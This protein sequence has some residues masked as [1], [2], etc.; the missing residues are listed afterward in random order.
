MW[1]CCL[2]LSLRWLCFRLW[3]GIYAG[4][5]GFRLLFRVWCF[6]VMFA[7]KIVVQWFYLGLWVTCGCLTCRFVVTGLTYCD[8]VAFALIVLLYVSW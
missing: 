7:D 3:V 8:L 5:L 2:S 1:R 6:G 4:S